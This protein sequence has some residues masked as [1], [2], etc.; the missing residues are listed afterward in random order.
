MYAL[1]THL[2]PSPPRV[3]ACNTHTHLRRERSQPLS[4]LTV[5]SSL[6]FFMNSPPESKSPACL[7]WPRD[8]GPF[9]VDTAVPCSHPP[10]LLPAVPARPSIVPL[11]RFV[12]TDRN[13]SPAARH[14]PQT[15]GFYNRARRAGNSVQE[16]DCLPPALLGERQTTTRN[17]RVCAGYLLRR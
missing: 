6:L 9:R 14:R 4:L 10:P 17:T 2:A 13:L 1:R 15:G 12:H 16:Q 11:T 5:L 3:H 8:P 7:S